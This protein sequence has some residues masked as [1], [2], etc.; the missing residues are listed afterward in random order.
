M[1]PNSDRQKFPKTC[2]EFFA[3]IGLMRMGLETQGWSALFANDIDVQKYKMYS[4]QFPDADTHFH[5]GDIHHLP[6]NEVPTV[7][8]ATASFPC[9]D[10]SLAGSRSGLSGKQS[11]AFWGFMSI[12]QDMGSRRPPIILLENVTGF[13]TSQGGA[14]FRE[15]LIALNKLGYSVDAVVLDAAYF[16]PQSRQRLFVVG[17]QNDRQPGS[18]STGLSFY[19]STL[20]PKAL[21]DFIFLHPEINWNLRDLPDP[22]RISCSLSCIV[23]D[24]PLVSPEW[25]SV[26]RASY[27][28][29]Q[30]SPRHRMVADQMI[31]APKWS[32]GTVF[33]RI[34]NE[35]SMA[36]L[37]TDGIAGCLR[38]PKGGSG[39]QI[40]F[41][42]GF[43]N[44]QVRLLTPRECARLMGANDYQ[45]NVPLN[46]ALFGFGDAVC[47]PVVQWVAKNYLNPV[48]E[49]LAKEYRLSSIVS[50]HPYEK[51][52]ANA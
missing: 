23:E 39:R 33:R 40:L 22:P 32:Y 9:T 44:Y 25:W 26:E 6:A 27:L 2:A 14:D 4:S 46:Q 29:E 38:T 8:L 28:L 16:V 3:G 35:K 30:M 24:L 15:A 10:L 41:K 34:R 12:L 48:L 13:L 20:R 7:S 11:S 50:K 43:G 18:V 21:A 42:G 49:E 5:L 52:L 19:G 17:V 1:K 45:I 31:A 47:V 37:R 36:E 51:V